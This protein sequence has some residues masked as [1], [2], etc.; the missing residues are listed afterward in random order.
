MA[1]FYRDFAGG[2]FV[3]ICRQSGTP[4]TRQARSNRTFGSKHDEA[5]SRSQDKI[6]DCD[7]N[8]SASQSSSAV[9]ASEQNPASQNSG[10]KDQ[11]SENFNAKNYD[12]KNSSA[13]NSGA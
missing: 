13:Q 10:G 6:S 3:Q 7:P 1:K 9:T 2:I 5:Q 8:E 4:K 11:S 12:T